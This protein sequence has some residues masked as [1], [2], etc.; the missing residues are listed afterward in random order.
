M[1]RFSGLAL[2]ASALLSLGGAAEVDAQA[3]TAKPPTIEE[4]KKFADD[5]EATLLKLWVDQSRADWV[6]STYITDD[7]LT[8]AAQAADKSIAAGVRF[9][10]QAARYDKLA[11][12]PETAR[13]L[14]LL[15]LSLTLAAPADP[16]ESAELTQIAAAMEGAYG[17][18]KYCPTKD[19]CLDLEDITKIMATSR[20]AKELYDVW[21]GWHAV[22][23]PIL[24]EFVRYVE[25]A[26][27]GARELGF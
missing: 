3:P 4:A 12:P 20:D 13:K 24:K 1:R 26:N 6:K 8:L 14:K 7:T 16:S 10:K 11:L 17:K 2:V 23:G 5:A 19:K 9:A 27:K 22:G 25:L 21:A 18:G 15:K